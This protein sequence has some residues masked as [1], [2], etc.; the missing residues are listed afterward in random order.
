MTNAQDSSRGSERRADKAKCGKI[1]EENETVEVRHGFETEA[2]HSSI[3][4]WK[5]SQTEEPSRLQS[6]GFQEW[7]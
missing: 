4:A 2:N 5:I 6:M 7:T 1:W 3:V